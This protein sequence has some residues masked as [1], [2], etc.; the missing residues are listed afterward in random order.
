MIWELIGN[1]SQM[2]IYRMHGNIFV[3]IYN[4]IFRSKDYIYYSTHADGRKFDSKEDDYIWNTTPFYEPKS[5]KNV[6]VNIF[7]MNEKE[8]LSMNFFKFIQ[9]EDDSVVGINSDGIYV[10]NYA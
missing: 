6:L 5:A 3:L 7:S 9:I 8:N 10:G 2:I 4:D 1:Q